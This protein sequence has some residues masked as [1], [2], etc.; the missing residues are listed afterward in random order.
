MVP[1]WPLATLLLALSSA[2]ALAQDSRVTGARAALAAANA[3]EAAL[4]ERIGRNRAELA[5]ML[6]ALQLFGRDPPPALLTNAGDVKDAV[7][8][9]ILIRA[10]TPVL[11]QRARSLAGEA[12][13]LSAVRRR[14]AAASGDLFAAESALEDRRGRLEG[15][16]SDAEALSPPS[17]R[18]KAGAPAR[19]ADPAPRN[20]LTPVAGE[21]A[22]GFGGRLADGTRSQGLAIRAAAGAAVISP[23]AAVVDYAGPLNGWGQVLILRAGGGC[24]MVLS[25]LGKISVTAGQSVAAGQAVGTMTVDGHSSKELYFEVRMSG[26]PV[27]PAKLMAGTPPKTASGARNFG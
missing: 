19:P 7:R 21:R 8:A 10:I 15:V 4:G 3:Q 17:L 11:E 5:R 24:H 26:A 6:G 2:A 12:Q 27:N 16:M 18:P 1:R 25:G 22:A 9:A 20:L 13:A 14:A 23:A